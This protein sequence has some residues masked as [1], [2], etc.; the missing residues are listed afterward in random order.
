MVKL[1]AEDVRAL[2]LRCPKF[3]TRDSEEI[4]RATYRGEIFRSFSEAEHEKILNDIVS[5]D[6]IIP[7]LR[8]FFQDIYLLDDC[9]TS[10]KY[11]LKPNKT[12]IRTALQYNFRAQSLQQQQLARGTAS[13]V[14]FDEAVQSLWIFAL[15]NFLKLPKPSARRDGRLLAKPLTEEAHEAIVHNFAKLAQNLGFRSPEIERLAQAPDSS[16]DSQG[17]EL[18]GDLTEQ[19]RLIEHH[20]VVPTYLV[21][22]SEDKPKLQR[23]CGRP[24]YETYNQ[25]R[26]FLKKTFLHYN[27]GGLE[28]D[29]PDITAF[30]ILRSQYLAFFNMSSQHC[31]HHQ[32]KSPEVEQQNLTPEEVTF[33]PAVGQSILPSRED[34][35]SDSDSDYSDVTVVSFSTEKDNEANRL[36]ATR[37]DSAAMT[38]E[39]QLQVQQCTVQ[40][41]FKTFKEGIF[42][43]VTKVDAGDPRAIAATARALIRDEGMKLFSVTLQ[44]I[45]VEKCFEEAIDSGLN[46]I[47]VLPANDLE[48]S[49][50]LRR[51]AGRLRPEE[52]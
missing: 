20:D 18:G 38:E 9:A 8:T 10:I 13:A 45:T 42:I 46:T 52:W 37:G 48:M 33:P 34:S 7:S 50:A 28:I 29:G 47:I 31:Q 32:T 43:T 14:S 3:C 17:S 26:K 4:R 51:A 44:P 39:N 36:S 35:D 16:E 19:V 6:Y 12:T 5:F 40:V 11:L 49:V 21:V 22:S 41:A 25:A 24:R 1:A 2:E 27:Y 15:R 23:R 30:F